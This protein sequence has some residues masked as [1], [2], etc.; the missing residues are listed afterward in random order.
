MLNRNFSFRWLLAP[1]S[2]GEFLA[3]HR[4]RGPLHVPGPSEKFADV[5]SWD[6]LNRLLDTSST[7][8]SHKIRLVREREIIPEIEYCRPA[9]DNAMG[10]IMR[11]VPHLIGSFL[12]Q[13]AT[14]N[15]NEIQMLDENLASVSSS[16]AMV[17]AAHVNC[18]L[19]SSRKSVAA[20]PTHFD[21]SDVYVV[22]LAGA[23]AWRV[24]ECPFEGATDLDGFTSASYP[25]EYHER[26][27]GNPI[28]ELTLTPGDFLYIPKGFYHDALA[29]ST[30]TLHVTF[31]VDEV[32]GLSIMDLLKSLLPNESLFREPMPTP[33]DP[34]AHEAHVRELAA[35]ITEILTAPKVT[36]HI[37]NLQKSLAFWDLPGFALPSPQFDQ[38]FRLCRQ[39]AR[40]ERD[41]EGW[42]LAFGATGHAIHPEQ[43]PIVRWVLDGDFFETDALVAAFE[44][45]D[46]Q[47][48]LELIGV[49][50]SAG[51]IEPLSAFAS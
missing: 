10:S 23:K 32:R 1:L 6:S 44:G 28:M 27:K 50:V 7:W 40:L 18:N 24:Y 48:V 30:A 20:F 35:R 36:A 31:G 41:G 22:H 29:S 33:D 34:V 9:F 26:R 21:T 17:F 46:S 19:Y 45:H 39:D 4:G 49:L 3:R 25:D 51:L 38:V 37:R 8:T 2:P 14:I 42:R 12:E 5:F 47:A 11:P 43:E 13:G 16:L 15:I